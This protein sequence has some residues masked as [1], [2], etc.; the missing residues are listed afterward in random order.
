MPT[1]TVTKYVFRKGKLEEDQ[2]PRDEVLREIDE[3]L[4][5]DR[6][7]LEIMEKL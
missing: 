1:D 4:E 3:L 6:D 5:E 2:V 7:F